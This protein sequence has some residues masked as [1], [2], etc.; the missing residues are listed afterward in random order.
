MIQVS[1][2]Y[3]A[4]LVA[5]LLLPGAL[6]PKAN[7][8][9]GAVFS[10]SG[11]SLQMD[12][13]SVQKKYPKSSHEF[14]PQAG[15]GIISATDNPRQFNDLIRV[16][17]GSYIIRLIADGSHNNLYYAQAEI[18]RGVVRR[19]RLSFEKPTELLRR[20]IKSGEEQYPACE[21]IKAELIR[22]YGKPS[23]T[24]SSWEERLETISSSWEKSKEVLTLNCGRYYKRKKLFAMEI[25]FARKE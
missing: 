3:R 12:L 4:V 18:D 16:G 14:W 24:G 13:S 9:A 22:L 19:L 20:P 8:L 15:G 17:S 25:T 5:L 7:P 21:G 23:S 10:Y 2:G 1:R 11:F 6:F